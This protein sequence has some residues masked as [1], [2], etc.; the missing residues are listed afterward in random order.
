M[1]SSVS[2]LS[3]D[4]ARALNPN[5]KSLM[6]SI[7]DIEERGSH[8][9]PRLAGYRS[10]L[11]LSFEDT[12]EELKL[13]QPGGWPDNPSDVDHDRF[14]QRRGERVPCLEDAFKIID[15]VSAHHRSSE[16]LRLMVHCKAGVSR[17][18]D[19]ALWSAGFTDV[20]LDPLDLARSHRANP[21]LL[22]LM[23]KALE[24]RSEKNRFS[25]LD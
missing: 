6:I 23:T 11:S 8:C 14:A 18:A 9:L 4:R 2:F 16:E 20:S 13:V 17:S 12:Y 19:V 24:L 1:I 25:R 22:R 15:F 7:L 21:R 10:V 5:H 3:L